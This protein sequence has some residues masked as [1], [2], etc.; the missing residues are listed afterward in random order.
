MSE[1][2]LQK[3]WKEYAEPFVSFDDLTLGRWLSQTLAQ[4]HGQSWR[5]SH[6]LVNSFRIAAHIAHERQIWLK[7]L[8]NT[9]ANFPLADCCR[10]PLFPVFGREVMSSGLI[11]IHCEDTTIAFDDLPKAPQKL[12]SDWASEYGQIHDVA[13][14]DEAQ[15][16]RV[17]DYGLELEK[18]R[19]KATVLL[20]A[21]PEKLLPGLLDHF[22]AVAWDDHDECLEL[23]PEDTID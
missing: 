8:V 15:Q 1:E 22:P 11:C 7:H 14:W 9:P 10:A 3:L 20:K 6:P 12:I 23:T 21:I 5:M 19:A 13:H 17:I 16:A 2:Q 4:L 18:A